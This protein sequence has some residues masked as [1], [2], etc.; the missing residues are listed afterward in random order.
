MHKRHFIL[1][2][3]LKSGARSKNIHQKTPFCKCRKK[4]KIKQAKQT[5]IRRPH[6]GRV[7]FFP[8]PDRPH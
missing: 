1:A 3:A 5:A 4:T 7:L 8:E 2:G 6:L